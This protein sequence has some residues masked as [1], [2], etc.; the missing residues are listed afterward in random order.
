[1]GEP[2]GVLLVH[3]LQCVM[4]GVAWWLVD[5]GYEARRAHGKVGHVSQEGVDL[6]D[7]LDGRA[8]LLEDGLE[9]GN[10]GGR[11][12]LDGALDQVALGIAGDLAGAVD[13]GGGL[14]GLGLWDGSGI[15][16]SIR[17]S[18]RGP[19]PRGQDVRRD[20]RLW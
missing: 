14:D 13:G 6:D 11:L 17:A 20:R 5:G 7:L 1:M 18:A 4:L 8:G 15:S 19:M 9:V 12:L 3:A 2:L 16:V 10:A